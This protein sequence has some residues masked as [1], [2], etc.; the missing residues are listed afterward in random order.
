MRLHALSGR[1]ERALAQYERLRDALSRGLGMEPTAATRRLR[2]E[3]AAGEASAYP[4]RGYRARGETPRS[5]QAQLCPP[6]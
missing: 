4:V 3:I 5:R 2:D 1:P 6:R